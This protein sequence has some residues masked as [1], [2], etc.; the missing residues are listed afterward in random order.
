MKIKTS[1]QE[2]CQSVVEGVALRSG[3]LIDKLSEIVNIPNTLPIDGGLSSNPYFCQFF[4]DVVQR[5]VVV[6][7]T[8]EITAFGIAKLALM[9][10]ND[11][12]GN[13]DATQPVNSNYQAKYEPGNNMQ[14]E[15]ERF[16]D[17]VDR[18]RNWNLKPD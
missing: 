11:L 14:E 12:N 2:L 4:A 13:P 15:K 7:S 10:L 3:Q 9:S 8:S 5:Q 18:C 17:A 16:A 6:P 1:K